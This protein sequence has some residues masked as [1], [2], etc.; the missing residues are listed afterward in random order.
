MSTTARAWSRHLLSCMLSGL[1]HYILQQALIQS[2]RGF[3]S[4]CG[5]AAY[6]CLLRTQIACNAPMP[7]VQ[8]TRLVDIAAAVLLDQDLHHALI[9]TGTC[10]IPKRLAMFPSTMRLGNQRGRIQFSMGR[11]VTT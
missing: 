6:S 4:C 1:S 9:N 5:H 11:G 10:L 8:G 3:R 7:H 2:I